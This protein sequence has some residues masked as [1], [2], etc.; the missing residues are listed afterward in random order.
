MAVEL[1][2]L[3]STAC[4]TIAT[5]AR[6]PR[7]Q[8]GMGFSKKNLAPPKRVLLYVFQKNC[9]E[10]AL[11][12][13]YNM[14]HN[15]CPQYAEAIPPAIAGTY[16]CIDR[17]PAFGLDCWHSVLSLWPILVNLASSLKFELP[18]SLVIQK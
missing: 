14:V 8:A 15:R 5:T 18:M 1:C 12:C 9:T 16:L 13:P 6:H 11:A 7:S 4:H 3:K 10:N 2:F 17:T